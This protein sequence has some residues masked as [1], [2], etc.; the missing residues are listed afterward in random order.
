[1]YNKSIYQVKLHGLDLNEDRIVELEAVLK[2]A[3][4][5]YLSSFKQ[6]KE[7][8]SGAVE[9][10]PDPNGPVGPVGP[11]PPWGPQPWPPFPRPPFPGPFPGF[12]ALDR[13]IQSSIFRNIGF[14]K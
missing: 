9:Y 8:L 2:D 3:T 5:Q 1:M 6:G 13:N 10:K 11:W 12:I 4:V 14:K 7:Y